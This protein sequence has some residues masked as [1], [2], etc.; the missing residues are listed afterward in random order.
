M[1]NNILH[2]SRNDGVDI[3]GGSSFTYCNFFFNYFHGVTQ[4]PLCQQI[5]LDTFQKHII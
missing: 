3:F 4:G 2:I 1:K 5:K